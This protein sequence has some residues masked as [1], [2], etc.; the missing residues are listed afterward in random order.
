[1]PNGVDCQAFAAL[2]TGRADRPPLI[3]FLGSLTW[4][5]NISA[6]TF[7]AREVLPGLRARSPGTRLRIVGRSPVPR[8]TAL[9]GLPGVEVVADAPEIVP[10]LR[11][12]R[13]MAVPLDSGGGTRLKIL[14]AFAA[15]LPVVSTPIGCEGIEADDGRHLLIA[16][17]PQFGEA[18]L[19][20]LDGPGPGV[21][22]AA[23]ARALARGR[24]DWGIVG[25]ALVAAIRD[26]I[27]HSGRP[28][29]AV[30]R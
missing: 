30:P 10:H 29:V 9:S 14:E 24:Y 25:E 6:A 11:E 18:L 7:L 8:V 2:P 26:A 19:A 3:L 22:L 13:V 12:A 4:P 23:R 20:L 15:G 1:M 28:T 27:R 16:D 17:R 5:P 21:E